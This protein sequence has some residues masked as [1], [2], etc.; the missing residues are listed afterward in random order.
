MAGLARLGL[1][2]CLV[3]VLTPMAFV[4]SC[5]CLLPVAARLVDPL[6]RRPVMDGFE[7]PFPILVV[8][9]ETAWVAMVE[10]P[11]KVPPPPPGAT[12]LVPPGEERRVERYVREHDPATP[13]RDSG[14]VLQVTGK[15]AGRQ[16]IELFLMGD[17]Y[18]GGAYDATSTTVRPRYRKITGPGFAL[19]FGSLATAM[20]LACWVSVVGGAWVFRREIR[21]LMRAM[22]WP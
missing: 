5:T 19:V 9:G 12:Y 22:R 18:W 14:W 11:L 2:G 13:E 16:Q 3:G 20:N 1:V 8:K 21:A 10:D 17:G 15:G 7:E 4:A 6:T